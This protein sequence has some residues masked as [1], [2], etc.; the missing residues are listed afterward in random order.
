MVD[1]DTHRGLY[2]EIADELRGLV[3][4]VAQFFQ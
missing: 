3:R 2:A 4:R 1:I